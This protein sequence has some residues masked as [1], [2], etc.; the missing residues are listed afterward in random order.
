MSG[1]TPRILRRALSRLAGQPKRRVAFVVSAPRS[2]STWLQRALNQHPAVYCT[3]HRLFGDYY[4]VV[5]TAE[6]DE[7]LRCTLDRYAGLLHEYHAF[8]ALGVSR[9]RFDEAVTAHLVQS[10]LAFSHAQSGKPV[11]VD[12]VTPYLGTAETVLRRIRKYLPDARLIQLTRD[13]RDVLAS[14]VFD[15]IRRV[16]RDHPRHAVFVERRPGARVARFFDDDDIAQWAEEWAGPIRAFEKLAPRAPRISYEGM[17]SDQGAVLAGLFGELSLEADPAMI[18]ACVEGATFRKMSGGRRAGEGV[19]V[20]KARKGVVGDW[21][22]YFTR[23]DGRLF[24]EIAGGELIA[25]GYE[26]DEGWV[27]ALPEDLDITS[28]RVP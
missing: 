22:N 6:G 25:L 18:A 3:E 23:R 20:A 4:D 2:G 14:G 12:K 8:R 10:M 24:H 9:K 21:R 5:P 16:K 19:A 28:E 17:K 1:Y 11:L 26:R 15:W 13:G 27:D 7:A